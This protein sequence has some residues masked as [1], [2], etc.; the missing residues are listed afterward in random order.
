MALR[1]HDYGRDGACSRCSHDCMSS[2]SDYCDD[3]PTHVLN[4][5]IGMV[6]NAHYVSP[7]EEAW[8]AMLTAATTETR[9]R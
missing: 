3:N 7:A 6:P 4:R 9:E 1:K 8:Y 5:M 2:G